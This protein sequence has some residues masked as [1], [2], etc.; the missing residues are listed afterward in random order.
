MP[1]KSRKKQLNY[2]KDYNKHRRHSKSKR[3]KTLAQYREYYRKRRDA[4][5]W[6]WTVKEYREMIHNLL[7]ERDGYLCG[8]CR[9]P[10]IGEVHIDHRIPVVKGGTQAANNLRLAHEFCNLSKGAR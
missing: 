3:A 7:M 10:L 9:K 6:R 4:G 5:K 2:F 8:I 1:Y